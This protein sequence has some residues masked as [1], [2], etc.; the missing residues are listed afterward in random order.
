MGSGIHEDEGVDAQECSN[1]H[2]DIEKV[3]ARQNDP[4]VADL[5]GNDF[6]L[7]GV[8]AEKIR[9]LDVVQA[10]GTFVHGLLGKANEEWHHKH[11]QQAKDEDGEDCQKVAKQVRL[12][13]NN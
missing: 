12:V 11:A 4:K 3:S 10:L 2:S 6:V 7:Q 13:G 9:L 1:H 5:L 8:E